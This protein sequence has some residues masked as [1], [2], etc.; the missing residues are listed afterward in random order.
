M[1][2]T[3]RITSKSCTRHAWHPLHA[4]FTSQSDLVLYSYEKI[5]RWIWQH[6]ASAQ[7][8]HITC[9]CRY[10]ALCVLPGSAFL[11][12]VR[13][14]LCVFFYL[15]SATFY[16]HPLNQSVVEILR[17]GAFYVDSMC[18]WHTTVIADTSLRTEWYIWWVEVHFFFL[19]F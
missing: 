2:V 8:K 11:E 7:C 1:G 17:I 16:P 10:S 9:L 6:H 4:F 12:S 15:S 14:W 19:I 3:F 13:V 5:M 18:F